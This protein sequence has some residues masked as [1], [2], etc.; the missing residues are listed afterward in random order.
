MVTL[1]WPVAIGIFV[2]YQVKGGSATWIQLEVGDTLQGVHS[3]LPHEMPLVRMNQVHGV[4]YHWI[5]DVPES[6]TVIEGVDALIC[7]VPNTLIAVRTADCLPVMVSHP[8]MVA[9]IH[10]GRKGLEGGIVRKVLTAMVEATGSMLGFGV[11]VGPGICVKCY[12]IDRERNVHMDLANACVG[13]IA[14]VLP[15]G[16][17][18]LQLSGECTCCQTRYHSYRRDATEERIFTVGYRLG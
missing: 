8:T 15:L 11:W 9:G 1:N 7:Q 16:R 10:A 4:D 13:Q 5:Q 18:A 2:V 6:D 3:S 14:D 17:V 12:Q